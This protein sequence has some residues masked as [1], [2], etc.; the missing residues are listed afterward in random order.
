MCDFMEQIFFNGL[1]KQLSYKF[2]LNTQAVWRLYI[3]QND[4]SYKA[5]NT[6]FLWGVLSQEV[7]LK[8]L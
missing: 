2:L 6:I 5:F 8:T 1:K 4:L 3:H 7:I